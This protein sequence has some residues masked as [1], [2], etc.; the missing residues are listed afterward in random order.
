VIPL[1][2]KNRR[3]HR[4]DGD[5]HAL[6]GPFLAVASSLNQAK[7]IPQRQNHVIYKRPLSTRSYASFTH[8]SMLSLKAALAN[9]TKS[10]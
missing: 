1:P 5:G 6:P 2:S 8:S 3:Y 4:N 7:Q 10:P 9:L